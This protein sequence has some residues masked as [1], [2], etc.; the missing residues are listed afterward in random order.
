MK[1]K[2][3]PHDISENSVKELLVKREALGLSLNL[4]SVLKGKN[5]LRYFGSVNQLPVH[6]QS[7]VIMSVGLVA[8]RLVTT[9]SWPRII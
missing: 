9:K 8:S 6:V 7:A 4:N 1:F 5:S 3:A 2:K